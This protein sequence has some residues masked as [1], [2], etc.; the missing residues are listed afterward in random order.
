MPKEVNPKDPTKWSRTYESEECISIWKYDSNIH[1]FNPI[2]VEHKWKK[3]FEMG[4]TKKKT[5][6]D[7]VGESKKTS[8]SKKTNS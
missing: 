6:G 1:Q 4:P 5:L 7:L 3:G 2:S 8:K